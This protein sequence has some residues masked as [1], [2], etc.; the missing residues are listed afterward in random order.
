MKFVLKLKI[1]CIRWSIKRLVKNTTSEKCSVISYG[2]YDI[3]PKHLVFLICIQTDQEK[4][5][6]LNNAYL[7]HELRNTLLKFDYPEDFRK[8]VKIDFESQENV[9]RKSN[10]DWYVHLK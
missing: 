2:A 6:L 9:D 10:G 3:S 5:R 7:M 8:D 4:I 1:I